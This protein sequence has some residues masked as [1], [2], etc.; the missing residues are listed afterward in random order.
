[1]PPGGSRSS[2]LA[3]VAAA[4]S[5]ELPVAAA[6]SDAPVDLAEAEESVGLGEPVGRREL[7]KPDVAV[8]AAEDADEPGD[9]VGLVEARDEPGAKESVRA[10]WIG[11]GTYYF[12][13]HRL[14]AEAGRA[15]CERR[16]AMA[17]PRRMK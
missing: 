6:E 3:V 12:D 15:R 1:M 16:V 17:R 13:Q 2:T 5:V 11:G 4:G 9:A 14:V 7:L 10:I 8:A